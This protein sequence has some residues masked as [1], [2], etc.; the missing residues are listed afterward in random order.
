MLE[1]NISFPFTP[2]QYALAY[3]VTLQPDGKLLVIGE[4][5]N[6]DTATGSVFAIARL[7]E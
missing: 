7:T 4:T 2:G 3:D 1:D 5:K 6:P